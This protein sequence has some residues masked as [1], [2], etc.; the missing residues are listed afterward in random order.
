VPATPEPTN[1]PAPTETP[2]P[3][4]TEWKPGEPM[5]E[6]YKYKRLTIVNKD[7]EFDLVPVLPN[8]EQ[9]IGLMNE[10]GKGP[11]TINVVASQNDIP[12]GPEY[13]LGGKKTCGHDG[14]GCMHLQALYGSDGSVEIFIYVD[15]PYTVKYP[16]TYDGNTWLINKAD[17]ELTALALSSSMG[18]LVDVGVE[19]AR[20]LYHS[21][22]GGWRFDIQLNE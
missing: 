5:P 16:Y 3:V 8:Q 10:F 9:M 14:R 20:V 7:P 22:P 21:G 4:G 19:R 12:S 1:T 15:D 18:S 6:V 13:N 17:R 11:V 2:K